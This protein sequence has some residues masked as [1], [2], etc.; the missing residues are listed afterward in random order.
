MPLINPDRS[1]VTWWWDNLVVAYVVVGVMY[2]GMALVPLFR[3]NRT[4][5][6][7]VLV[8]FVTYFPVAIWLKMAYVP[9]PPPGTVAE[10]KRPFEMYYGNPLAFVVKMPQ[11]E[12]LSDRIGD[13]RRS[14]FVIFED[15]QPL[16][17]PHSL[18]DDIVKLG[19]GRFSHWT[20]EGFIFSTSDNYTPRGSGRRFW[21]VDTTKKDNKP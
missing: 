10:L 14:P 3:L 4:V 1:R 2:V 17:P 6:Y 21:I 18:H 5:A 16:G 7:G 8:L 15:G 13:E 20:G 19:G 12:A 11:F 9:M